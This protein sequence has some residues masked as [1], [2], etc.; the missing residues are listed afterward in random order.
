MTPERLKLVSSVQAINWNRIQDGQ[1]PR[2]LEPSGEQLLAAGEGAAVERTCSRGT[3]SPP[4]SSCSP[5]G[6]SRRSHPAR[7]DPGH[8]GCG[9]ADPRRDHAS[10]RGRVHEHRVHGV[11]AREELL[12][13]LLDAR[14]DEGD[15][16]GVP[17]VHRESEPQKKAQIIMDYYQGD[18]P[19]KR[20]WP[21]PCWSRSSST[22]VLPADLLVVEG[23]ADEHG[24]P[25]PPHHP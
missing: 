7:H 9:V 19:L 23:E 6:C 5:C 11:G 10:R 20:K 13:D 15:R 24:R 18:D 21:P 16:R 12:L 3:R 22:R 4:T 2:G 17:L 25:D 8:R 14:V 1:G